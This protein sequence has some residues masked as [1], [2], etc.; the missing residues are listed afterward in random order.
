MINERSDSMLYCL[1]RIVVNNEIIPHEI[2][3]KFGNNKNIEVEIF[4]NTRKWQIGA[5]YDIHLRLIDFDS[6]VGE[7]KIKSIDIEGD[8]TTILFE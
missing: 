7:F 4:N 2:S 1:I 8:I 3:C 6:Y 5:E